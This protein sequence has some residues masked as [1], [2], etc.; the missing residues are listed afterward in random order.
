MH[1]PNSKQCCVEEKK[2]EG[3]EGGVY[4]V[5]GE[6]VSRVSGGERGVGGRRANGILDAGAE[7]GKTRAFGQFFNGS[8]GLGFLLGKLGFLRIGRAVQEMLEVGTLNG[9]SKCS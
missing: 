7:D 5:V 4:I 9:G 1:C 3:R 2:E 6:G 8:R